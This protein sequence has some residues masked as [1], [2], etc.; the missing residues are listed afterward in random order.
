MAQVV[1]QTFAEVRVVGEVHGQACINVWHFGN[2]ELLV[3][4][5]DW[6]N[7]LQALSL[8]MIQCITTTLLPGL[9]S[10]YRLLKVEAKMTHPQ[11]T[12]YFSS[13]AA[14]GD[15]G[16]QGPCS[17]SFASSL[18]QLRSG[19]DGRKGR[20]R[21]FLPPAGEANTT[22]S[23]LD[24]ATMT[25]LIAFVAC[26]A[27]KFMNGQ[28]TAGWELGVVSRTDLNAVGGSWSGAFRPVQLIDPV[29]RVAIMSSRK[30]ARGA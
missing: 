12:D 22:N 2:S 6:E 4:F 15:V 18:L 21:K 9:S 13:L 28:R 24:D 5:A 29:K 25:A 26:V 30:L 1:N 16:Q 8:A 27:G 10:D 17:H 19:R 3:D 11:Q 7:A 14:P 20:G 23:E